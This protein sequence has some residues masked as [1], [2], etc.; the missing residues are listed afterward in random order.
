MHTNKQTTSWFDC[1]F[2]W[3]GNFQLFLLNFP[4]QIYVN[5][6]F[7]THAGKVLSKVESSEVIFLFHFFWRFRELTVSQAVSHQR[8]WISPA[9]PHWSSTTP[10]GYST[11]TMQQRPVQSNRSEK[12]EPASTI[13]RRCRSGSTGPV[14]GS[15]RIPWVRFALRRRRTSRQRLRHRRRMSNSCRRQTQPRRDRRL[16]CPCLPFMNCA[17]EFHSAKENTRSTLK[18]TAIESCKI[19]RANAE[20]ECRER[21]RVV[22]EK[23]RVFV[24]VWLRRGRDA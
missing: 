9:D 21:K 11:A 10:T 2:R 16:L 13:H 3:C 20:R 7:T 23:L 22:W 19:R 8:R 15:T 24:W 14:R 5:Y 12:I 1:D 18:E 17:R 6:V 4:P